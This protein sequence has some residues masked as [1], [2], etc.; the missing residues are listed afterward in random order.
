[1]VPVRNSKENSFTTIVV[2]VRNSKEN[3]FI[4]IVADAQWYPSC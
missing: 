2:P 1:V 4:T 3:S